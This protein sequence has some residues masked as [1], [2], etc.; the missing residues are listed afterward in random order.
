MIPY[1]SDRWLTKNQYR[2]LRRAAKKMGAEDVNL[3][4]IWHTVWFRYTSVSFGFRPFEAYA[5]INDGDLWY[6]HFSDKDGA[7]KIKA[8]MDKALEFIAYL[9]EFN[10]EV[11]MEND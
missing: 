2:R 8:D 1:G 10:C 5:H 7:E 6:G 4:A 11:E 9:K 3:S